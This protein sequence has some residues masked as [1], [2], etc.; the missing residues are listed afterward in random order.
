M[1]WC[2]Q[3]GTRLHLWWCIWNHLPVSTSAVTSL[4]LVPI[5]PSWRPQRFLSG[6][7]SC[8]ARWAVCPRCKCAHNAPAE[9]SHKPLCPVTGLLLP[10]KLSLPL[11]LLWL[12]FPQTSG[13]TA[14]VLLDSRIAPCCPSARSIN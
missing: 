9:P 14:E 2:S 6:F 10:L 8:P 5:C 1:W 12:S 11:S 13:T 3:L 7:F 4:A